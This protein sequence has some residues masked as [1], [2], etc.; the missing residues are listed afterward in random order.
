[1]SQSVFISVAIITFN[2]AENIER[3]IRSVQAFADEIL[4]LDSHSTDQTPEICEKLGIRFEQYAF[5]G[6]IQQKNRALAMATHPIVF[7]LDA[8]EEVSPQLCQSI[9]NAKRNWQ[10]DGYRLNRLNNY[11]GKWI[12]HGNWYPDRKVRLFDRRKARWGGTNPHD[13][14]I[15]QSTGKIGTLRGDLL[16]YTF[17]STEQHIRQIGLFTDIASKSMYQQGKRTGLYHLHLKPT[18]KFLEA[19]LLRL[20]FL[21]GYY[22]YIIAKN[23][24]HATF[25]KYAKLRELYKR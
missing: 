7:A 5:D 1:M 13:K 6:H 12:R 8:D 24:A 19:Y 25:L 18:L 23:S 21:D 10:F 20:G 16:H 9:L 22:G 15:M 3:C 2:E 17:T 11:C 14:V 4:V